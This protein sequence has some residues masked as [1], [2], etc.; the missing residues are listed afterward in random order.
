M[1]VNIAVSF[2]MARLQVKELSC[3]VVDNYIRENFRMVRC[4]GKVSSVIIPNLTSNRIHFMREC[5]S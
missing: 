5:F 4:M 3:G 2:R 1:A